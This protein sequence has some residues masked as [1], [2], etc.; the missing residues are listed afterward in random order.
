MKKVKFI[1]AALMVVA[2]GIGIFWACQKEET[3]ENSSVTTTSNKIQKAECEDENIRIVQVF[4]KKSKY[5]DWPNQYCDGISDHGCWLW[6]NNNPS[7]PS[8]TEACNGEA[9]RLS[10]IENEFAILC[11]HFNLNHNNFDTLSK[12]ILENNSMIIEEDLIENDPIFLNMMATSNSSL[13]IP[14]G[15]YN[16]TYLNDS[17]IETQIPVFEN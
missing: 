16:I 17:I 5:G 9:F 14:S 12:Y 2:V 15:I 1:L 13:R 8:I 7:V 11:I 4:S 10:P 6:F 3:T